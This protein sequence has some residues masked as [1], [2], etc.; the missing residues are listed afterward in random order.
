MQGRGSDR[1]GDR[2]QDKGSPTSPP[3]AARGNR[4]PSSALEGHNYPSLSAFPGNDYPSST[5]LPGNFYPPSSVL[6]SNGYLSSSALSGTGYPSLPAFPSNDPPSRHSA[7]PED[8]GGSPGPLPSEARGDS[9]LSPSVLPGNGYPSLPVAPNNDYLSPLGVYDVRENNDHTSKSNATGNSYFRFSSVASGNN[10]IHPPVASDNDIH[11]PV[12]SGNDIH[13]P[14]V[15]G[16]NIHPPIV[17]GNSD[18]LSAA[19]VP[20][21]IDNRAP[22]LPGNNGDGTVAPATDS[23]V[24]PRSLNWRR[25]QV[26]FRGRFTD[27][28]SLLVQ[29]AEWDRLTGTG[30]D[31]AGAMQSAPDRNFPPDKATGAPDSVQSAG[32]RGDQAQSQHRSGRDYHS[33]SLPLSVG[34]RDHLADRGTDDRDGNE[35]GESTD[36]QQ[37]RAFTAYQFSEADRGSIVTSDAVKVADVSDISDMYL[38]VG[39]GTVGTPQ[40]ADDA[41]V[42]GGEAEFATGVESDT[43]DPLFA[44]TYFDVVPSRYYRRPTPFGQ[45]HQ[46]VG[47]TGQRP[48]AVG[49][50]GQEHQAVG[51]TG[52]EHQ[53]IGYTGQEH[54]TVGYTGQE[55]QAVGY[56]GQ[57]HQAIG[58][59]GQ[60]PQ[61]VGYTGQRPQAVGY[62]GQRPQAVGYTG[63]RPQAVGYTERTPLAQ[64]QRGFPSTGGDGGQGHEH[65][66]QQTG[67]YGSVVWGN[68][69]TRNGEGAGSYSENRHP[70]PES[71]RGA[72]TEM[73]AVGGQDRDCSP[74]GGLQGDGASTMASPGQGGDRQDQGRPSEAR[75]TGFEAR[76]LREMVSPQTG[77]PHGQ[78]GP[79]GSYRGGLEPWHHAVKAGGIMQANKPSYYAAKGTAVSTWPRASPQ[80][81]QLTNFYAYAILRKILETIAVFAKPS[82]MI[83]C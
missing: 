32:G 8:R 28:N 72:H 3:P 34:D 46:A 22:V 38:P 69:E 2:P 47:D 49:Y 41:D 35:R 11:P 60:R 48:Q 59:T 73:K 64:R 13:P 18:N 67:N 26:S 10:D 37:Q 25:R 80:R 66:A 51:Y 30:D 5:V 39:P 56:T 82:C 71:V 7:R 43:M 74:P 65:A 42:T 50:T 9:F 52:Q 62:T 77:P 31:P 36:H 24:S 78:P 1:D 63:Q 75:R 4:Y 54:Q 45:Q 58:Y 23:S 57:E 15:S 55:H 27:T 83:D 44:Q 33:V 16:N 70:Y 29:S 61:A 17:S 19:E 20:G 21:N 76:R 12:A 79:R 6:P 14:V 68:V 81:V 53:A 40:R